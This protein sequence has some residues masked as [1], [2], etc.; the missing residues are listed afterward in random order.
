MSRIKE[1]K[2]DYEYHKERHLTL[3]KRWIII[4]GISILCVIVV[5][6]LICFAVLYN[7]TSK[8]INLNSDIN[9]IQPLPSIT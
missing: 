1:L 6:G 2:Q 9:P 4:S 3:R 5:T 7:D 8:D